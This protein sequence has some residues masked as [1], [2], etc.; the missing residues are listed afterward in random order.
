[1]D[2]ILGFAGRIAKAFI[3][4]KITGLVVITGILLGLFAFII[5]PKEEDP[6]IIVPMVDIMVPAP[7][8]S[9][10]EMKNNVVAPMERYLWEIK[11]VKYIYSAISPGMDLTTVRFR[12]GLNMQES[13]T[14]V[15][16]K[17]KANYDKIPPGVSMPIIKERSIF[18]V[19][20]L[21]VTL[22]SNKYSEYQLR[23][24][25]KEV[26]D[27]IK[28]DKDVSKIDILG[29]Q[30]R[31]IRLIMNPLHLAAYNTSAFQIIESLKKA[32]FLI[33]AGTFPSGNQE[34]IVK[35]GG[36][37]DNTKDIGNIVVNVI[38]GK[39]IY[40][41]NLVKIEDGPESP[42]NYVFMD[43]GPAA[44]NI[45]P[46][47]K[48][49]LYNAVTIT[50]AKRKYVNEVNVASESL[51]RINSLKASLIPSGIHVVITRNY[52]KKAA[53]KTNE[54]MGHMLISTLAVTL[55]ILLALGWRESL[56]VLIVIPTTLA[57]TLFINY[58]Y[59][60]TLNRVT[61]FALIFSIGILVDNAIVV[62]ENIY[63]HFRIHGIGPLRAILATDEV[64][65]PT[66]LATITVILA[67]MPMAFVSGMMGPYMRAIPLDGS[68]AMIVSLVLAFMVTP[69]MGYMLLKNVKYTE[70]KRN[71][72]ATWYKNL[73]KTLLDNRKKRLLTLSS[74]AVLFIL[75]LSLILFKAV[76]IKLLPYS[77]RNSAQVI[78]SMPRGTPL[79]ETNNVV[80]QLGLYLQTVPYVTSYQT[81]TGISAP[82]DFNGLV[83][84]YFLRNGSN[85]ADIQI[86][87]IP[88][89]ERKIQSHQLIEK[90]RGPLTQIAERY[91]G[92]IRMEET[93]PGPPVLSTI[94]AEIYGPA[95]KGQ[96]EIAKQV[97]NILKKTPGVVDVTWSV[98][99]PQRKIIFYVNKE[100]AALN[101]ISTQEISEALNIALNGMKI[102]LVHLQNEKEPVKI[103]LRASLNER[104][105]IVNLGS[106]TIPSSDGT[107]I[108]L[109]ELVEVKKTKEYQQPIM[110]KNLKDLTYVMADTA[111]REASPIYAILKMQKAVK[112]IQVPDGYKFKQE[113]I[114]LPWKTTNKYVLN[115]GGE[116]EWHMTYQVFGQMF[117]AFAAVLILIYIVLVGWYKNFLIPFALMIPIPLTL[118]GI[119]PGH[120]MMRAFFTATSM[121]GFIALAGIIMRNSILLIDFTH[122]QWKECGDLKSS[123][124]ESGAVRLRPI[125][126]TALA[127]VVGSSVIVLDP[128]FSGLAISLMF[129]APIA[130]FLTLLVIPLVYYEMFKNKPCPLLVEEAEKIQEQKK[131]KEI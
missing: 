84:H 18:N 96:I 24:V 93:P 49:S 70:E 101:G 38:N 45:K 120:W 112:S 76:I 37:L 9:V 97:K 79:E 27:S 36:F 44:K 46:Q 126:L 125:V 95:Q 60:F 71:K 99:H 12:V 122:N 85:Q 81:Y 41:R 62:I 114:G 67:L 88:K 1:M 34:Y 55:L 104:T 92:R 14:K 54:L 116:G 21:D 30:K 86:N 61:F 63:R 2:D 10:K 66:I 82:Y 39:P 31:Q 23:R 15:Y 50:V 6:D 115:W 35:A 52:G 11:G 42:E 87:F 73:I 51:R 123:L 57:I 16:E 47:N 91:K 64:G 108:P 20:I 121:I 19:P 53:D 129:G 48:Y 17:I 25:A 83:R 59:R 106:I 94:V 33:P 128:V 68:A 100:K 117:M 90:L 7:G 98:V 127:V 26:A 78:V 105:G 4:S 65:D 28:K 40:L 77:D 75:S 130:T 3:K 80:T 107:M 89:Q 56:I 119:I 74:V 113:F 69:W 118:I 8:F 5:T 13:L 111:G 109:S 58:M 29:G 124:I 110:R 32:N 131:E 43:F 103:F 102:G 22:W 72:I